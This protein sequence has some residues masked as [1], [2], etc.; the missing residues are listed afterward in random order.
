MAIDKDFVIKNGIEVNENLLYADADTGKVGIGTTEG[1]KK[2]VVIGDVE[3]SSNLSVG[4]TITWKM[5]YSQ[6]S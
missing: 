4:T 6:V 1:D 5:V 3:V 2:L